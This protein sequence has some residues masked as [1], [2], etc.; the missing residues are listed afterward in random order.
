MVEERAEEGGE[1]ISLGWRPGRELGSKSWAIKASGT[2]F[3]TV[4][5]PR[6][7]GKTISTRRCSGHATVSSDIIRFY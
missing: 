4:E 2:S 7:Y 3:T 5:I 6:V 1:T